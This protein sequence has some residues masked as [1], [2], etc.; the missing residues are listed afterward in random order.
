MSSVLGA[1]HCE[2]GR[3]VLFSADRQL[4][5]HAHREVHVL[6]KLN[7]ADGTY[8]VSGKEVPITVDKLALIN[9]WEPHSALREPNATK[10]TMLALYI[11]THWLDLDGDQRV[12]PTVRPFMSNSGQVTDQV[13]LYSQR[14]SRSVLSTCSDSKSSLE[15]EVRELMNCVLEIGD[16]GITISSS[17]R[18][19]DYRIRRATDL[20]A[21][22]VKYVASIDKLAAIVGLS[23]S[24][25]YERFQA[26]VGM[27]PKV[28]ADSIILERC[29][30]ALALSEDN[31][32][33][34]EISAKLGFSAQSNFCRF[35]QN[36]SGFSPSAYRRAAVT[37][38]GYMEKQAPR[39]V[40]N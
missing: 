31:A 7:G 36:K 10:S 2:F 23:R 28:Y 3:I 40:A 8:L 5:M 29:F 38:A 27:S 16:S 30:D 22:D 9:P 39:S 21:G 17:T 12:V 26:T 37:Q 6:I 20:I 34:D 15:Q 18:G 19:I 35:F 32:S 25:F 1:Y 11:D 4:A 24:H 14:I 33:I 13:E